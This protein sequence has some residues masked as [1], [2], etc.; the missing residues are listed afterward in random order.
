MPGSRAG[1]GS[2]G[3]TAFSFFFLFFKLLFKYLSLS[4]LY[5]RCLTF[6]PPFQNYMVLPIPEPFEGSLM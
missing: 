4:P 1:R 2:R 5:F 6:R 3:F